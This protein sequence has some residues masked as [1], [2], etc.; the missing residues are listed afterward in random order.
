MTLSTGNIY[1]DLALVALVVI[2]I[3][4]LS[5]WTDT[6][7]AFVSAR[8]HR[9]VASLRPFTCALCM[10]WWTGLLYLACAGSFALPQIAFVAALSALSRPIASFAI[11][12]REALQALIDRL[13][14]RWL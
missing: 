10:V 4:D 2:Y 7:L 5:G 9:P 8:R 11:F 13:G 12:I 6:L 3:V 14:G 1:A